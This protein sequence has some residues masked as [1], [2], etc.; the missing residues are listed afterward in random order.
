[1]VSFASFW[2]N[3]E[4]LTELGTV[5]GSDVVNFGIQLAPPN[6]DP[7]NPEWFHIH[8]GPH[9]PSAARRYYVRYTWRGA[10][11]EQLIKKFADVDDTV[12]RLIARIE[13]K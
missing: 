8:V 13:G 10:N 7:N 5:I 9:I 11:T 1:M 2:A 6:R 3:S 12:R 4:S